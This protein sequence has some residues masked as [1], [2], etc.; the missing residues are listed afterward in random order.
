VN[1]KTFAQFSCKP[2]FNQGGLTNFIS[3][4]EIDGKNLKLTGRISIDENKLEKEV[5]F[6][7]PADENKFY[8]FIVLQENNYGNSTPIM[9]TLGNLT[10]NRISLSGQIDTQT[11][12]KLSGIV[13]GVFFFFCLCSCC[14][15]DDLIR[16]P[17][18]P[19]RKWCNPVYPKEENHYAEFPIFTHDQKNPFPHNEH[20][21]ETKY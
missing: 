19:F 12:L 15:C 5:P 16:S 17:D 10:S 13:L 2:G 21:N 20:S 7:T 4:Y 3:I 11:L 6:I 1:N 14:C 18:N 8:E 9:L